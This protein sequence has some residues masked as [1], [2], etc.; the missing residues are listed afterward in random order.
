MKNRLLFAIFLI[1]GLSSFFSSCADKLPEFA[2]LDC[3]TTR[4]TYVDHVKGILDAECNLAG[5][6][7]DNNKDSFGDFSTLS[8]ARKRDIYTWVSVIKL[9]PP[10]GMSFQRVDSIRCW[11]ENAYLEN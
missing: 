8:E 1:I 2:S 10:L 9:M 11:S 3:S 4:I 7:D 6:H 5:C